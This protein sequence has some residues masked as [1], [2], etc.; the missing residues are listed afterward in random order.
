MTHCLET[1]RYQH[2]SYGLKQDLLLLSFINLQFRL[3]SLQNFKFF[4]VSFPT[5]SFCRFN[6]HDKF[7]GQNLW[8]LFT[9]VN[10]YPFFNTHQAILHELS[11]ESMVVSGGHSLRRRPR[12]HLHR[13]NLRHHQSRNHLQYVK[14]TTRFMYSF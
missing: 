6:V 5:E 9:R 12:N 2:S 8:V 4:C 13:R 1:R 10:T 7:W 3:T 14:Y 11:V